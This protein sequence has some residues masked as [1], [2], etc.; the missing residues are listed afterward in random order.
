MVIGV[1]HVL[2]FTALNVW[3]VRNEPKSRKGWWLLIGAYI[4]CALFIFAAVNPAG[5]PYWLQ[6]VIAVPNSLALAALGAWTLCSQPRSRNGWRLFIGGW[7]YVALFLLLIA[8]RMTI[9][10]K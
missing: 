7:L 10:H 3:V 4:Y 9:Y 1:P 8:R 6:M 5:W 2:A